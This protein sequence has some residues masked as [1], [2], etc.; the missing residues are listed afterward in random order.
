[1]CRH[2]QWVSTEPNITNG[3]FTSQ[4]N[5][6]DRTTTCTNEQRLVEITVF[7]Q[8]N[9]C[10]ELNKC[11]YTTHYD[12]NHLVRARDN[13]VNRTC[14]ALTPCIAGDEWISTPKTPKS[15]RHCSPIDRCEGKRISNWDAIKNGDSKTNSSCAPITPPCQVKTHY[16]LSAPTQ[17]TN[18]LGSFTI[19][20]RQCEQLT[21]CGDYAYEI[22]DPGLTEIMPHETHS[23]FSHEHVH[24][25]NNHI[26]STAHTQHVWQNTRDRQCACMPG[27]Y[28]DVGTQNNRFDC[29]PAEPCRGNQYE[30]IQPDNLITKYFTSDKN[31]SHQYP[32]VTCKLLDPCGVNQYEASP[33]IYQMRWFVE[34]RKM[35]HRKVAIS[36]HVCKDLTDCAD[37]T[38]HYEIVPATNT[39]DRFCRERTT[40]TL[41]VTYSSKTA[42]ASNENRVCLPVQSCQLGVS[43]ETDPP[44]DKKTSDRKCAEV[45]PCNKSEYETSP[46]TLTAQRECGDRR[47]K[48]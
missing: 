20:N 17:Y 11:D 31:H 26:H 44:N 34:N 6:T 42:F 7:N 32:S 47:K 23:I 18:S 5:C 9:E 19:K 38:D 13:T 29:E 35:V 30:E 46:P 43:Y 12:S 15:D 25:D 39:S 45:K 48:M 28:N 4:R 8:P 41:N 40:C 37:M 10:V 1:V 33:P 3:I 21:E 24:N 22:L 36:N 16:E 14:T 27:H 2:N